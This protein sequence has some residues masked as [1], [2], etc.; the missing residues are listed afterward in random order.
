MDQKNE[1]ENNTIIFTKT[2]SIE[3]N[4]NEQLDN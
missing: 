3:I 4:T 1:N 2:K